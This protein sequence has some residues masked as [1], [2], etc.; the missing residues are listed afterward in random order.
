MIIDNKL[1]HIHIPRTGGRYVRKLMKI[2]DSISKPTTFTSLYNGIEVPHLH[3]PLYN[4]YFLHTKELEYFA[5][6]R[7]PFDRFISM[8]KGVNPTDLKELY[9]VENS[10]D[11]NK[12]MELFRQR[13]N[14]HNYFRP[15]HEFISDKTHIWKLEDGLK[16]EFKEWL[17]NNFG[18]N[19]NNDEAQYVKFWY[20]EDNINDPS[21]FN[22]LKEYIKE[23]YKKDYEILRYK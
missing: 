18:I 9:S 10:E 17:F 1:Y 4:K 21:L 12:V 20:D 2:N 15:Q 19:I 23:Y 14:R 22:K 11:F 6:V 3:Y 5:I 8:V 16:G 13:L 7:N